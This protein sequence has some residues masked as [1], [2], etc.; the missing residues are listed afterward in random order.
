MRINKMLAVI[1]AA[2]FAFASLFAGDKTTLKIDY[3]KYKLKN[4]LDVILHKTK[5]VK[6]GIYCGLC[7]LCVF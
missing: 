7:S 2:F 1:G 6:S 3:E 4:G 5:F